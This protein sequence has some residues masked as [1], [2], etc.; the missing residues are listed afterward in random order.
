MADWYNVGR[1]TINMLPDEALLEIFYFYA[2]PPFVRHY[3][4]WQRLLQVCQRW[5]NLVFVSPRFLNVQLHCTASTPVREILDVWPA[6]PITM[7]QLCLTPKEET[8]NILAAL[9][10]HDQVYEINLTVLSSSF[11]EQVGQVM[12]KPFPALTDLT[13]KSYYE[14]PSVLPDSFLGGSAPPLQTLALNQIPFPA[15]PNI[16]LSA[17][18][19]HCLELLNIPRSGYIYLNRWSTACPR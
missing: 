16:L 15:L 10:H 12:Q 17:T 7:W 2:N 4:G 18:E 3:K 8:D 6:L 11:L 1:M 13:L 9:E 19:L 14:S 5:R